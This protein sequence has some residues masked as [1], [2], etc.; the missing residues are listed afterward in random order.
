MTGRMS[1]GRLKHSGRL[2]AAA[3]EIRG[4]PKA[5]EAFGKSGFPS[6]SKGSVFVGAGDSY[7]AALVAFYASRAG[8]I[9]LDPYVLVAYPEIA[10][11]REVFFI[12]VSGRTAANVEAAARVR[13]LAKSTTAITSEGTNRLSELTDHAVKLPVRPAPRSPGLMSFSLSALAVLNISANAG[14]CDFE[15]AMHRAEKDSLEMVFSKGMTYFLGNASAHAITVYSAAKV[16]E[17]LGAKAQGE[18]LEEFSHLELFS[19]GESDSVN[20]FSCFDP[21]G[22]GLKLREA[23]S[24]RGYQ[25]RQVPSRGR[26]DCEK[27]FHAIFTSQ[28][29]V[30]RRAEELGLSGPTFLAN[31]GRLAISDSRIY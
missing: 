16:Y 11:G 8:C 20:I 24:Q 17:F 7:A 22:A 13:R 26:S 25:A 6:A 14:G 30:L 27:L 12:S 5:L 29:A 23:L 3:E 19:L 18:L 31:K 21:E 1:R 15:G 4:Q 2:R 10:A 9:A 28:L